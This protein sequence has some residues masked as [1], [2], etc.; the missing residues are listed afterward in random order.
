MKKRLV[1]CFFLALTTS[2]FSQKDSVSK[3]KLQ[4]ISIEMHSNNYP[5][6]Y[7]KATKNDFLRFA[8]NDAILISSPS[9]STTGYGQAYP[10]FF[11]ALLSGKLFFNLPKQKKLQLYGGVN[12][13]IQQVLS[14]GHI[15]NDYD[16]VDVYTS[17][18]SNQKIYKVIN[19][20]H[21]FSFSLSSKKIQLPVG[22]QFVTDTKK[23]FWL[24]AGIEL[25][26]GLTFDN[27]YRSNRSLSMYT[28]TLNEQSQYDVI[29]SYTRD[30]MNSGLISFVN[31]DKKIGGVG[32]FGTANLPITVNLRASKKIRLLNKICLFAQIT[33]GGFFAYNRFTNNQSGFQINTGLG[34]RYAI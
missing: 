29:T 30:F 20:Q 19:F 33:P 34:L 17:S 5:T 16:T 8:G 3:F 13:G 18:N 22:V 12:F 32:F 26:P 15:V 10:S 2:V 14:L 21:S 23:R 25:C 7:W 31:N 24:S 27:L 9:G 4:S 6:H 28:L 1:I 11:S